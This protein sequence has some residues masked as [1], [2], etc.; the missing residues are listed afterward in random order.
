MP[1]SRSPA[2]HAPDCK[3]CHGPQAG[4]QSLDEL[5]FQKSACAAAQ[6]GNCERLRELLAKNPRLVDSDGVQGASILRAPRGSQ[7]LP[8]APL[9]RC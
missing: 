9:W 4:A 1:M 6:A 8:D 3:C 5:S 7:I 2:V